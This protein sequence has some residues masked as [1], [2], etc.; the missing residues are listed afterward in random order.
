LT[1][2]NTTASKKRSR[3]T[4]RPSRNG[5]FARDHTLV[6]LHE[7]LQ[8]ARDREQELLRQ[9]AEKDA[10]IRLVLEDR[11]F[12]PVLAERPRIAENILKENLEEDVVRFPTAGDAKAI[13]E[14]E[15]EE[16]KAAEALEQSLAEELA[17]IAESH[18]AYHE[19]HPELAATPA[20]ETPEADAA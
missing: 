8:A 10:Q 3:S 5:D 6:W 14:H 15:A 13:E 4:P 16:K 11:F 19:Q 9:L 2:L 12:K 1:R 7:E 17:N 20:A 18:H